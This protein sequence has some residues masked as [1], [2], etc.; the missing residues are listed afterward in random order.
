MHVGPTRKVGTRNPRHFQRGAY[1]NTVLGIED[2][3]GDMAK[4]YVVSGPEEG[5]QLDIPAEYLVPVHPDDS[6]QTVIAI[7]GDQRG[8]QRRTSYKDDSVWLMEMDQDAGDVV[9]LLIKE[10]ELARI[11]QE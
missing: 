3:E 8:T 2:T 9:A 7:A 11:W 10:E 6:G 1:D 4:C 5:T